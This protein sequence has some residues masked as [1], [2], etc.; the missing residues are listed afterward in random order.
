M[1]EDT[2]SAPQPPALHS[3]PRCEFLILILMASCVLRTLNRPRDTFRGGLDGAMRIAP[4]A[5]LSESS[6]ALSG[7]RAGA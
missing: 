3:D 7:L 5:S 6:R 1:V 4:P 2:G